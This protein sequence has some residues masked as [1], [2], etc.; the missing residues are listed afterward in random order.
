MPGEGGRIIPEANKFMSARQHERGE[1]RSYFLSWNSI[2]AALLV[3]GVFCTTMVG[4]YNDD[5]DD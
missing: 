3:P 2:S 1:L 4:F 5:M